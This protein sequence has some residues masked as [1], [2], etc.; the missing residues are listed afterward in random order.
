M[1]SEFGGDNLSASVFLNASGK[2]I[3][4]SS[5]IPQD[6]P[7]GIMFLWFDCSIDP[8]NKD[9]RIQWDPFCFQF[10][11]WLPQH[12]F[13]SITNKVEDI[14]SQEKMKIHQSAKKS[15]EVSAILGGGSQL[16][17]TPEITETGNTQ[18][19]VSYQNPPTPKMNLLCKNNNNIILV[20]WDLWIIKQI[21]LKCLEKN[22]QLL[23]QT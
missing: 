17:S 9:A 22:Q 15:G 6:R 23:I 4:L 19:S 14:N 12:H 21:S 1:N 18:P 5:E 13:Y 8:T 16:F 20:N 11:L 7:P 10:T 3:K 2:V